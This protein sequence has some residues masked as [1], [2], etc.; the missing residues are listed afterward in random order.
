VIT[1][2][3]IFAHGIVGR[4]D[5]PIPATY[6]GVAA[7]IVLVVS[8]ASLAAGWTRPRLEHAAERPLFRLPLAA[9]AVLGVV[10]FGLFA[11]AVYAGLAGTDIEQE[12]LAPTLVY[13]A[14]WVGIPVASLVLGDVFRLL[15][16]WRA[17]GRAVGALVQRAGGDD[18][19]EA[20]PY[21]ARLGRWPAVAGLVAFALVE[22]CWGRGTDPQVLAVLALAYFAIQVIGMGLYGVEPWTRDA[23]AFG[24][25]F[26]LFASLSPVGRRPDGTVVLRA[27][28]TGAPRLPRA[29][30]TVA[31][32]CV[33]IGSTTFDG[34]KEG[35]LFGSVVPHLQELFT[36][37]GLSK[38]AALEWTF[39]VGLAA[40]IALVGLLY[41][42]GV[43][44]MGRRREQRESRAS[45]FAHSLIPIAAAYV[46]AHYFS[47]LAYQ[48]QSLWPLASDP[49]G[50]GSDWFGTAGRTIDYGVVSATAIWYVQ[51][52]ALVGGHVAALVLAHDRALAVEPSARAATRSQIVMLMVMVAFTSLGLWLLS[53]SNS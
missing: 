18:A 27:P 12:N 17:V 51:V 36:G 46:I 29:A 52:A 28:L 2:R 53:V 34:A 7:A 23:D 42:A 25:Y 5:L 50:D 13:V 31:L 14:F 21:P 37:I 47:L 40:C 22:L 43:A 45:A 16:P 26:G 4:A 32:L 8:F 33:A 10:G 15:S 48:G 9:D 35:P 1:P 39:V 49:L 24:V 20:L 30:G 41:R 19:A 6:F 3:A 44:G 38:G 11:L